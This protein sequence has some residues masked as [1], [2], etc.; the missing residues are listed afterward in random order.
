MIIPITAL[1]VVFVLAICVQGCNQCGYNQSGL[2]ENV[3]WPKSS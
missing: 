3:L 2:V 1:I